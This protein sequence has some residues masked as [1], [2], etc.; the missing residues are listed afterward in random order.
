MTNMASNSQRTDSSKLN[1]FHTS[2]FPKT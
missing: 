1:T 2:I